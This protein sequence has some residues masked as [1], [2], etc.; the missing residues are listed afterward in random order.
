MSHVDREQAVE[1]FRR[2]LLELIERADDSRSAFA[3]RAG[4]DRSTLSQLLSP[5]N[6]RLPRVETVMGIAVASQVSVDWLLGLSEDEHRGAEL[7]DRDTE[8]EAGAASP[9]DERLARWHREARGYKI[10]YVP[11]TLPDLLKT[12]AVIEYEHPPVAGAALPASAEQTARQLRY[13]RDPDT[14]MEVCCP[15][16]TLEDLAAGNGVWSRLDR[17]ARA[18]QVAHMASLVEELFPTF[19]WYL[20]DGR[21]RFSAPVT[22]FGTKRAV[23]YVGDQYF[24]FNTA[25]HIRTLAAHFDSLVKHATVAPTDLVAYLEQLHDRVR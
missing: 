11:T 24:V 17:A 2:R 18:E 12:E 15:Q 3:A 5:D 7:L 8:I 10:R 9:V 23:I 20:Y 14:E 13:G 1:V 16:Q 6:R 19:R 22:V 21:R 25:L 4:M